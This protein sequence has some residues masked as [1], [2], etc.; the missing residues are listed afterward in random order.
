M[1]FGHELIIKYLYIN[2]SRRQ[3]G[4][5]PNRIP[6]PPPLYGTTS[7]ISGLKPFPSRSFN[8]N[9]PIHPMPNIVSA[10]PPASSSSV[11]DHLV[12]HAP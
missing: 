8:Q 6:L 11:D 4:D 10:Q 7:F 9:T 2:L 5:D 12:K 3:M 1:F